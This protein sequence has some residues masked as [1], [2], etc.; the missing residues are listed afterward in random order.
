MFRSII[1]LVVRRLFAAV[2]GSGAA[3][4]DVE[5][6]VLRHQLGVLRRQVGR[7]K[8]RASDRLFLA[9]S[10]RFLGRERWSAFL[11]TPQT[12]LRWHREVVRR[13]WTFASARKP[14]RPAIDRE[15]LDAVLRLAREN[16]R[17]G[18]LRI[19][20]ELR[21]LG[22]RVG[23]TTVRRILKAH[24]LGPAPR[25]SG[26]TWSQFLKAQAHGILACDFFT[27]ETLRLRTLY[28]LFFIEIETRRVHIAGVTAHPD[29]AWVSQQARNLVC[30]LNDRSAR[31]RYL[32]RDRD[33]KYSR[34]FDD[35]FHSEGTIVLR[36]PVR[37]PRANAFA[38]RWV[39]SVRTE[40]LDWILVRGRR[41]LEHV[42]RTYAT[43][44]NCERPHRGLELVTPAYSWVPLDDGAISVRLRRHDLLGG[45]IHEYDAAA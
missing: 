18:Y 24:G 14:G 17:W 31:V 12:L 45:L 11:I 26:P 36:T 28:V 37:A 3:A 9:A 38:E 40:C 2:S 16:P 29:S 27:V 44:Y 13:K 8:W 39:R 20:G 19:R 42:L 21:K 30:S 41:H 5:I 22:V 7:P 1:Y 4:K 6:A 35:V 15:L 32:I 10:S 43:H 23:A 25:R 34:A 33:S